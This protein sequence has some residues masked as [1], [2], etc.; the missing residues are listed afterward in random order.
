VALHQ[1]GR[2]R[3]QSRGV[4]IP[5][6][7]TQ[8]NMVRAQR[9][10]RAPARQRLGRPLVRT[11][12][13]ARSHPVIHRPANQRV[14]ESE[15][16]GRIGR[17][18][19]AGGD[20]LVHRSKRLLIVELR[21]RGRELEAER[22]ACHRR[23]THQLAG[24]RGQA[25]DLASHRREHGG[26]HI[27]REHATERLQAAG[28]PR[29]RELLRVKRISAALAVDGRSRFRPDIWAQQLP[30]LLLA[31][32]GQR[33]FKSR[34]YAPSV[35]KRTLYRGRLPCPPRQHEQNRCRRRMA[36]KVN[37]RFKRSGIGPMQII[38]SEHHRAYGRQSAHKRPQ[39]AVNRNR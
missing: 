28:A 6:A 27:L 31:Q 22:I 5:P 37:D 29:P 35:A 15:P 7:R 32:R 24:D 12:P 18:N 16:P 25:L 1:N 9:E 26:G 30:H 4:G 36:H 13:P 23:A 14:T 19:H 17:A 21:A 10:Q 11:Q 39:G 34:P 3:E 38:Q 8:R 20:Q 2:A 33:H